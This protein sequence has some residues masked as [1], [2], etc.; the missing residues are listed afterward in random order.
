MEPNIGM[1]CIMQG[2]VISHEGFKHFGTGFEDN[3]LE[4]LTC[5]RQEYERLKPRLFYLAE[6]DPGCIEYKKLYV[7]CSELFSEA[8]KITAHLEL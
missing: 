5:L 8:E 1:G 4:R 6:Q 3:L 2:N 7:H